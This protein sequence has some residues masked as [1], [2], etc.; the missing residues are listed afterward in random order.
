MPAFETLDPEL[1]GVLGKRIREMGL[2]LEGS[3]VEP[4]VRQLYH[5]LE[6]R[7]LRKFRPVCYLT[8]EWGCPD[9]QPV[10]GIPFYLA[11]PNLGKLERAVDDLEDGREIMR[12]MRHEAGHVFNYAYR[13]YARADWRAIFGPFEQPYRDKYRPVPFS[14]NYV[15][16]IEG[17]YAQKHPDEDFAET[18]AVWLTPG[19]AWRRRYKGWPAMRK[20]RY[21][22]KMARM[23]SEV[24]PI[25]R[26]GEVDITVDDM[27][28]TVEEFYERAEDERA[29][30][31]DLAMDAHLAE[32]FLT[33]KPREGRPAATIVTKYRREL[34]D[35]ITYWT[36]VR[37]PVVRGLV[38]A[39]CKNCERMK[40]WGVVGQEPTYL[41]ALT[42]FGTTLAM[43]FLQRGN[44]TGD[45][46][47]SVKSKEPKSKEPK[48]IEQKSI[49]QKSKEQKVRKLEAGS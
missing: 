34:T 9:M 13:L 24:E 43:N 45:K 49:E 2:R 38:D 27:R 15:R 47:R 28:L 6:R 14:R 33:R 18:F 26:T 44:F 30:R 20:L 29:T 39:I 25:V 3:P 36:G 10:L 41:V 1:R 8:D 4:Y 17:W 42:A 22:D 12:Y 35:K 32:I 5:E 23:F 21:V 46:R 37:R 31:I 16:H 19:S 11:D 7:G 40:L 48:S